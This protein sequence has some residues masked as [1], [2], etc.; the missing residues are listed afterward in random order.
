ML[1][2]VQQAQHDA[3]DHL[4][5]IAAHA[6]RVKERWDGYGPK[7]PGPAVLEVGLPANLQAGT[8]CARFGLLP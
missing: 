7:E 2:Q 4:K 5:E 6:N 1:L 8:V 3:V